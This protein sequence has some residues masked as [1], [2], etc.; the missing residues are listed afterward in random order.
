[1]FFRT[2]MLAQLWCR[3]KLEIVV[4]FKE[5]RD[6]RF[7]QCN[8]GADAAEAGCFSHSNGVANVVDGGVGQI[9]QARQ[10]YS[11]RPAEERQRGS[12]KARKHIKM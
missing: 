1:M 9:S 8:A 2:V 4:I 7:P 10:K 5:A 12:W 11:G 3:C 6:V